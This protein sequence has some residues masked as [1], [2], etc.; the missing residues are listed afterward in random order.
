MAHTGTAARPGRPIAMRLGNP[1]RIGEF[2]PRIR[3]LGL[4]PHKAGTHS[5]GRPASELRNLQE[6]R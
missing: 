2:T 5:K 6:R 4:R 1:L 3:H